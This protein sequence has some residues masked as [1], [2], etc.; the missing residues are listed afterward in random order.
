MRPAAIAREIQ[1]HVM[2]DPRA[3]PVIGDPDR[4]QQ[5]VW[6]LVSNAVKFTPKNGRVDVTLSRLDSQVEIVVNDTGQG[7]APDVLPYVFDRFKQGDSTST[8]A[9]G[10]LG[11]GLALVRHLVELH[12]GTVTAASAGVGQGATFVV[13]LPVSMLRPTTAPEPTHPTASAASPLAAASLDDALPGIRVLVVDD[14]ADALELVSAMLRRANAEPRVATSAAEGI[15][16]VESWHP[17]VILSDL[18]MPGEDGYAFLRRIQAVERET[19]QRFPSVA[20]T[21][22][23]RLEDRVRTLSAGFAMHLPKPVDPAELV[24]VIGALARR[25]R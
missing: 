6:N 20:L 21:A 12:G 14:D 1:L 23:G 24:A 13:R 17:E 16:I 15:A 9:H 4:L 2:L 22:Y 10:G 11:L 8:R 25:R 19:G 7:I 18:E 5:V 3:G